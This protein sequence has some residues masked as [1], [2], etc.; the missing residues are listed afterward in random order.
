MGLCCSIRTRVLATVLTVAAGVALAPAQCGTGSWGRLVPS[1]PGCSDFNPLAVESRLMPTD[2]RVDWDFET[3]YRGDG[4]AGQ[5]WFAR[6]YAG[7]TAVFPRSV[8]DASSYGA[9]PVIPPDTTF[10]IGEPDRFTSARLGL[11]STPAPVRD[12]SGGLRIDNRISLRQVDRMDTSWADAGVAEE[13]R[14]SVDAQSPRMG[15]A[16]LMKL[17]GDRAR[18]R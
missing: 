7:V 15:M 5:T 13:A 8:Y 2:L 3:L 17:A 11:G 1:E 14:P 4:A 6:R 16:R 10:V 12:A 18:G 9:V